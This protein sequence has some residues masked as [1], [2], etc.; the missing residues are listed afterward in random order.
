MRPG[1]QNKRSRGRSS[2]GSNNNNG[3]N[4]NRKGSNP[5]T[6]TYDSSGPDVKIRGTA[7]HIAEKYMAL[8]RDSHSSGDRVMAE[9]YLQHAEH[10]NRIIAAAQAQMQE[11]VHR[12]DRDYND[13]DG[14]DMD[15]DEGDNGLDRGYQPQPEMPVQQPRIQQERVQPERAQQ[16]RPDRR[17]RTHQDRRPQP[18]A[19]PQPELDIAGSGPQPVIEKT[20]V[21]AEFAAEESAQQA[22]AKSDRPQ[23]RR[24][25]PAARPRRPRRTAEEIAAEAN[26]EASAE[27]KPPA[28]GRD[29]ANNGDAPALADIV[30]E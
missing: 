10:Y 13:R 5:L 22:S 21:E 12:D 30:S 15:G 19:Q 25:T 28:K 3:N 24:R 16:E 17:E 20:P 18:I 14:S 2:G 26:G 11:R 8:A 9:N 4:F 29:K 1:Q 6:R 27:G 7:Q 23:T